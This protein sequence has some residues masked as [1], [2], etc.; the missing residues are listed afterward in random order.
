MTAGRHHLTSERRT[1]EVAK[2]KD[3]AAAEV[4]ADDSS[5]GDAELEEMGLEDIDEASLTESEKLAK[6]AAKARP[7]RKKAD[8][9]EADTSRKG[10]RKNK[11]KSRPARK[12]AADSGDRRANPVQFV[13]EV[14]AELKKVV[15]PT[16]V[17]LVQ[18]FFV[19][20]IFVLII[21][22]F[23]FSL[24]YGLGLALLALLGQS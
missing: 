24:D 20:L 17:Q 1:A 22:A 6:A 10:R 7:V 16:R 15:W 3:K 8:E 13:R 4:P 2:D 23:V 21:I 18:Y 11:R 19:V 9:A 5:I 14:V 12:S